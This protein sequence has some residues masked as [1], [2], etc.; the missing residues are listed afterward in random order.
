MIADG[1]LIKKIRVALK[2]R[3]GFRSFPDLSFHI[4][5]GRS[6]APM[7]PGQASPEIR[8]LKAAN[9]CP[10]GPVRAQYENKDPKPLQRPVINLACIT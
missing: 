1:S 2:P 7:P 9:A 3:C 6:E 5:K 4:D 10:T 8:H